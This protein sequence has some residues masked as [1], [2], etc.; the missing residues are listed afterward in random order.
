MSHA[1]SHRPHI[2]LGHASASAGYLVRDRLNKRQA[3]EPA[4]P[5]PEAR[6]EDAIAALEAVHR[7][8]RDVLASADGLALDTVRMPHPAL[9]PL[10]VY[11]WGVAVGGHEARHAAQIQE[12]AA[13][14]AAAPAAR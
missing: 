5:A 12:V 4:H 6:Y 9:G 14:L 1:A 2:T 7:R 8:V 11:E 13:T 3:L 10:N